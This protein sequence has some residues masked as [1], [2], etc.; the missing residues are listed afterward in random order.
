MEVNLEEVKKKLSEAT[1][2]CCKLGTEVHYAQEGLKT[3]K[4]SL[5][6]YKKVCLGLCCVHCGANAYSFKSR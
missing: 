4:K 5:E 3:A 1:Q 2:Q 6:N